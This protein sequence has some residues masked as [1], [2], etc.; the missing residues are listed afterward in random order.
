MVGTIVHVHVLDQT[1]AQTVFGK[2]TLHDAHEQGVH[3]LV[4]IVLLERFLH[5]HFGSGLTLT[6]GIAGVVKVDAVGHFFAGENDLVGVDDD[7]IVA[8]LHVGGVAGFVFAAKQLCHFCAQTAENLVGGVDNH[9]L[10]LYFLSVGELG[11][12]ANSIHS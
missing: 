10:V 5:Q 11:A 4:L 9:P 1:T 2:H 3:A 6:T 7:D 8:A 12:I